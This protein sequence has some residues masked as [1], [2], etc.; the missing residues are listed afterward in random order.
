[1][2]G[3]LF[4]DL[5]GFEISSEEKELINHPF[6]AGIILFSRNFQNRDQLRNLVRQ[7][8]E[9]RSPSL[10]VGVDQEGGS[11]QRFKKDF[12]TLPPLSAIGDKYEENPERSKSLARDHA[13]LMASELLDVGVDFSFSPVVDLKDQRNSVIGNR[14]FHSHPEV[15][16]V[17]ASIY[18][19][20]LNL[21]G[22]PAI[23][24][25]FPGHGLVAEDSHFDLP[26]DDRSLASIMS[27]DIL[28]YRKIMEVGLTGIM[29]AHVLYSKVDD[30]AAGYSEIW[31]RRILRE[32]LGFNGVIF[33]DDL[34]MV[35]AAVSDSY[36]ERVSMALE[37]GCDSLLLCNNRAGVE[38]VLDSQI[39]EES[40]SKVSNRLEKMRS[41]QSPQEI[42]SLSG[43]SNW[44]R[45][46]ANLKAIGGT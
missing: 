7:I 24:K 8:K 27:N 45:A 28:P 46:K 37:A 1:M 9:V 30:R 39:L 25:H 6:V 42:L 41:K 35:G 38:E 12:S 22:M 44:V 40:A 15:V 3:R 32:E 36:V 29:M 10:L 4:I 21:C 43:D 13:W 20:T 16:S 5:D 11:V 2:D 33:S 31:M 14:A 18:V 23:A 34:N 17:L 19:K 26:V